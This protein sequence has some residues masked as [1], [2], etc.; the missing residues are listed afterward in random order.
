LLL[1]SSGEALDGG[2]VLRLREDWYSGYE[3]YSN[4]ELGV[5]VRKEREIALPQGLRR[6]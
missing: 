3:K 5:R 1:L 2:L 4:A 6:T